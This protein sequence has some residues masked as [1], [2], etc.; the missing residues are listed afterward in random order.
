MPT[1]MSSLNDEVRMHTHIAYRISHIAYRVS[2]SGGRRRL[3]TA[4]KALGI[5]RGPMLIELDIPPMGRMK[6]CEEALRET[7]LSQCNTK[8]Q[9]TVL[10]MINEV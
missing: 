3:C 4:A 1:N 8:H 7:E 6:A 10:P 5:L 2:L 9:K